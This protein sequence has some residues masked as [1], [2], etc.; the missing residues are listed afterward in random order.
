MSVTI[1]PGGNFD[2]HVLQCADHAV[3]DFEVADFKQHGVIRRSR[4]G[5]ARPQLVCGAAGGTPPRPRNPWKK[6]SYVRPPR[7]GGGNN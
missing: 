3:T 5:G 4:P 6:E 7:R 1:S 2:G